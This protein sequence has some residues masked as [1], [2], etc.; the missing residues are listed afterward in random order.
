MPVIAT[1]HLGEAARAVTNATSHSDLHAC[2]LGD[3]DVTPL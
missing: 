3:Y 2:S 1:D